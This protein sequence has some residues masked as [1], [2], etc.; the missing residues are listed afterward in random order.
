MCDAAKFEEFFDEADSDGSGCV[1]LDELCTILESKGLARG[2]VQTHFRSMD[3]NQ[4]GRV[5]KQ[6]YMIAVGAVPD[7]HW[8]AAQFRRV[9]NE[10]DKD[11]SGEIDRNELKDVFAEMG[12]HFSAGE[13]QRMVQLADAAQ[14]GTLN[15]K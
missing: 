4:D 5:T 11:N 10:F 6:E 3:V 15:C 2:Q 13:L 14:S 9:F 12:K 1:S 7:P 8:K